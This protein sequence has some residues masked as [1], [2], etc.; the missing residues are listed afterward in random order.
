MFNLKPFVQSFD[1]NPKCVQFPK[2]LM[3]LI[4]QGHP[5]CCTELLWF[6]L[7][8]LILQP[9]SVSMGPQAAHQGLAG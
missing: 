9:C 6:L 8:I 1:V 4:P 5:V 7:S 2:Q 3:D